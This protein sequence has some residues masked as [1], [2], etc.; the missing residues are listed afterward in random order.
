M[1]LAPC[2]TD[3]GSI[4]CEENDN[5]KLPSLAQVETMDMVYA[6]KQ[7][8]IYKYT[9]KFT[10]SAAYKYT[11]TVIEATYDGTLTYL[12]EELPLLKEKYSLPP[13]FVF[14][15]DLYLPSAALF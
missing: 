11:R 5:T 14:F 6:W 3:H 4:S 9:A 2:T 13:Q 15:T 10:Q 7:L 12:Q 8:N 1:A